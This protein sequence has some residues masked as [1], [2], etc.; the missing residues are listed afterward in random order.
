MKKQAEELSV[1]KMKI[2]ENKHEK[3]FKKDQEILE[4]MNQL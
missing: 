1:R 3:K 4:C 2:T